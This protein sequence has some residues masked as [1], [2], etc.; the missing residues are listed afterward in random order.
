MSCCKRAPAGRERRGRVYGFRSCRR[1]QVGA[2]QNINK[3]PLKA[4]GGNLI[5]ADGA[6][7]GIRLFGDDA[8]R[9]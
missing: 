3:Y 5:R 9:V 7:D 2:V 4:L 6:Q 1:H 8:V